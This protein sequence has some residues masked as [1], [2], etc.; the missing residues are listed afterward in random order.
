MKNEKEVVEG[1]KVDAQGQ[2]SAES[3]KVEK[4]GAGSRKYTRER[5]A[6]LL[7]NDLTAAI[8]FLRIIVDDPK[9]FQIIVDVVNER[10]KEDGKV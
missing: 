5:I 6:K 1:T 2:Q 10:L 3:K 7:G 4:A 8:S 9:V